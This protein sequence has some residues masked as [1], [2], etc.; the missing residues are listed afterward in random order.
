MPYK[1]KRSFGRFTRRFRRRSYGRRRFSRYRR[2]F[3]RK[4]RTVQQRLRS[5]EKSI[6]WKWADA[7]QPMTSIG[8]NFD[9]V[10]LMP[11]IDAGTGTGT[12]GDRIGDSIN[13]RYLQTRLVLDSGDST[14]SVR[15]VI[16]RFPVLS[17]TTGIADVMQFPATVLGDSRLPIQS[18]YKKD[19]PVKYQ[20]LFDKVFYVNTT[21]KGVKVVNIKLK[22]PSTGL[23]LDYPDSTAV[24]PNKNIINLYACSDSAAV[25]NPGI[26]CNTRATYC[27]A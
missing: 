16:V 17:G 6:E 13:L 25:P 7:T 14:N 4:P 8:Y 23:K 19:G 15:I 11:R 21:T 20:V 22:L 24:Q 3:T 27:D 18:L 2:T 10:N 5:I 1:R 12:L 26:V 9:G